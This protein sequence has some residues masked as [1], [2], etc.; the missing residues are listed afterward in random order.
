MPMKHLR[1]AFSQICPLA[2]IALS[3]IFHG[4]LQGEVMPAQPPNS[5][6]QVKAKGS[7][8]ELI[9]DGAPILSATAGSE[10]TIIHET[11]GAD[12]ALEQRILIAIQDSKELTLNVVI[13]GSDQAIAA[14]TSGQAQKNFSIVRTSHGQST[15]RRN[16]AIYDRFGDW[17]IEMPG[18]AT[19]ITPQPQ[20]DGSIQFQVTIEP[21]QNPVEI[22][23][24]PRFYQKHKNIKHFEPQKYDIRK[25]SVTGWCS[26]WA[27]KNELREE[28][29]DS[30]LDVWQRKRLADFG[31]DIIQIDD[32]FQGGRDEGRAHHP[33]NHGYLGGR[34][35][36]WLE[37]KE[38]RF[39]GGMT[40]YVDAVRRAGF[41][42]G[43]W[44]G[45]FFSDEATVK[46]H[47]EWFIRD[48]AGKPFAGPWVSYG[49][50][51]TVTEA[52]N[53]LVRPTYRGLHNA[54]FDYVKI[55]Q[56]RH[57]LYDNLNHNPEYAASKGLESD[58]IFRAYLRAAREELG[59]ETFILSCWGVLPESVGLADACRI[60]GDG[61]GP[62]TMQQ[63]NSWNGIVWR[64]DPD[65]CDVSPKHKPAEVGNVRKTIAVT[66]SNQETII[67]PALASIAGCLL[68]LSDKPE[69]YEDERNLV[70]IK[71]SSPVVFSVPGQLYDFDSCK[72]DTLINT[73]R[74]AILKGSQSPIDGD[75]HGEV[76]PWWLN[77]FNLGFDHWNVLHHLN[78]SPK[79]AKPETVRFADLGLD[80][81]REYH[82]YEFWT[83]QA[84]GVFKGSFE[85]P[86]IE[87]MGLHSFAIREATGR[88]QLVST[89]R[90]LS[91]GAVDLENLAWENETTLAGRSRVV[92]EDRYTLTL[93]L[94]KDQQVSAAT[95]DGKPATITQEGS[96]ARI[97]FT[98]ARTDSVGWKIE[99]A[100]K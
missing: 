23:F 2:A 5:A 36:T 22:T 32:V 82:V 95:F 97:S 12:M 53:R 66:S 63:Y 30:L 96:Y 16:N 60:G 8:F 92:A 25:N 21:K 20:V 62:V 83:D 75:Q 93:H 64:N 24:R 26:W 68:M 57:L 81:N 56:L 74:S 54:K 71:R 100:G 50:D 73:K 31:Y 47:P 98:P 89:N 88:P 79:S 10:L 99:F 14:E 40:A 35:E 42:P 77:E 34:P 29:I 84:L 13:S 39:P 70:G 69:V 11:Q 38:D 19:Q 4:A 43:V 76:C 18:G 33:L 55:D 27:Y 85:V 52:A 61:Y 87:S 94:P 59:N 67:R 80:G 1:P 6:A 45:C 51:A 49:I 9:Y 3:F 48:K 37:W 44:I 15:N 91:Q 90:H 86:A 41:S 28:H 78:W 58:D 7:K 65:H 17:M 72:T 46:E